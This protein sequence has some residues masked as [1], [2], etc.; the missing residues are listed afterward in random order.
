MKEKFRK[1]RSDKRDFKE[2]K[3]SKD[4]ITGIYNPAKTGDFGFVDV[5]GEKKGYYVY[6]ANKK[7]ALPG[8]KV[9]AEIKMFKGKP[10]AKIIKVLERTEEILIGE[11]ASGKQTSKRTKKDEQRDFTYGFVIVNDVAFKKDIFIPGKYIGEAKVGDIVGVKIIGW[12]AKSPE[13]KIVEVLGKKGDKGLELESIILGSGFKQG[14]SRGIENELKQISPHPTPLPSRGEGIAT[15]KELENRTDL[16]RLFTFTIDGEDAK[17]L[18]DAISIV[19]RKNGNFELYV[20]IADVS[21]Y[22]KEGSELDREAIKRGTSVYLADRVIPMLP[23]KL[24]NDLCS[25]NPNTDKLTLTCEILIAKDG[26]IKKSRVYESI[27]NTDFRL[28][29]K[30]VDEMIKNT[31]SQPSP[32]EEKEQAQL[33]S[34]LLQRRG[35]RGEVLKV[36]DSL[37][38]GGTITKQLIETIKKAE[39]LRGYIEKN[40]N[41]QGVL[42]FEFPETKIEFDSEKN[43]I[44]IKQY[45]RYKSNKI[46]EE[47]MISANEA[48]SKEFSMYPF[49]HRI[50][51]DPSEED[52]QKLQSTLDLFGVDFKLQDF[53]TKE[54]SNLLEKI[55]KSPK[56]Y[57][58]ENI[59][60]RT[61]TKAIYSH[62]NEGHFGLGLNYYSHFTSPIR[63]YPDLQIHR[64]IKEKL[65]GKLN[66]KRIHHYKN[67]LETVANKT[68]TQERKA[69]KLEYKVRD[70][71][72]VRYYKDKVGHE[73]EA[74]IVSIIP[75]GFFV[76]LVDTAE[77]FI[78]LSENSSF[79]HREDL[80]CFED[81]KGG[82]NYCLGDKIKVKLIEADERLIRLNFE[83]V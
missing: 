40:K 13:G 3:S 67:I 50:H 74:T 7:D 64:I 69:E 29:Y 73:F 23:E 15:K 48:V 44:G 70:F 32:L 75:K 63:R 6:E 61:L 4:T 41:L 52:I 76:Q 2:K 77:G 78:D 28:T 11:F 82:K 20:H 38:F 56:K 72:I 17:D 51:P 30:E 80:H 79:I 57:I 14:F 9:L 16:R 1:N 18:D 36:G 83:L 55:D 37:Q 68:S 34:P 42:N 21:H 46:I 5:E 58:L 27:I 54:F 33:N 24:S 31:S 66:P 35:A 49:L 10:E 26:K 53:T 39:V 65:Q 71:F 8:D 43:P 60:L 22:I 19:E 59:I 45:P 12:S 81:K 47:F 25:L 62:E